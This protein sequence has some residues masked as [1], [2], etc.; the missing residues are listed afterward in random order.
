M[1]V[2][3]ENCITGFALA[4]TKHENDP[5]GNERRTQ[6]NND[7]HQAWIDFA[8]TDPVEARRLHK[9]LRRNAD[10]ENEQGK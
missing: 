4:C 8:R 7:N 10:N 1:R 5:V 3:R 6:Q 2:A 9:A